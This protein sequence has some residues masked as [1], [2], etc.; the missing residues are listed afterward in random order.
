MN[1]LLRLSVV[2]LA[3]SLVFHQSI[4]A[5]AQSGQ[6]TGKVTDTQTGDLLPG[7]TVRVQGTSLGTATNVDGRYL[8]PKTPIGELTL[9]ISSVG[10]QGMETTVNVAPG[11]KIT[12]DVTLQVSSTQLD[13]IVITGLRKSQIDAINRKKQALN[14]K[15]VLTTNDIGRLPDINVAEAAQRVS[16]VSIETDNG[17]GRF[18]SIRG[19]QP[20]LN[21]VT[22][23]NTNIGST[24]GGRE[25][26]LDLMPVEMISS[27]EVTKAVTPDME[28]SAVGGAININTI[29]AFDK[30]ESQFLIASVDGLIQEQQADYGDDKFPFRAA[31][32]AGKRFGENEKFGAVVS[33]NFFR[34]DFTVSV[35]DPDRWQLLQGTDPNGNPSP[36]YLGPNEIEIQMEDNERD[37]YGVTADLEYQFT[38]N[39]SVYFRSLYT[40][41][42]ERRLNS[43]FELTVAG[44]G[45][46][47]NQT[48]TSGQFTA[49]SGELDLSSS[50]ENEDLYSFTLGT[51]HRLGAF[52]FDVY[53]T[54]S[55]A[56]QNRFNI[57]GTYENPPETEPLLAATYNV[58]PFF[59]D[60][61]AI[62]QEEARDP[63]LY[64]LRSLNFNRN[65]TVQENMYEA[66]IDLR[67]DFTLGTSIPAYI[68]IGGRYRSREKTVDNA[69]EEYND[70]REN[71]LTGD[72]LDK[73]S[74]P[75][76]LDQFNIEPQGPEQGGAQPNVHGDAEAFREFFA[77]P[78]TL[79]DTTRI[80]FRPYDTAEEIYDEDISYSEDV[81][82]GYIMG[83]VD[84][85][86][87]TL[88]AGVRVEHTATSSA[89]FTLLSNDETIPLQDRFEQLF[90]EN[91]Y[92]NIMPSVHLKANPF[93]NFIARLSWT[94]TLA[95]PD[96]D[97]LA[98]TSELEINETAT[99]GLFDGTFQGANAGLQPYEAM[100]LDLSLEYYFPS[101]GILSSG[102][103]YKDIDSY[104]FDSE[105]TQN[106]IEFQGIQFESLGLAR[107]LNLDNA[108]VR[109]VEATYDQAFTFLPGFWN[110]FGITA[111]VAL[112]DS[113]AEYPNR[114]DDD[115]P[116]IRQP[117]SVFNI[118]PYY[119]KYGFELRAAITYRSE[120][121]D[122]IESLSSGWVGD[123]VEAGFAV[124]DFDVYE[125]SRTAVD[126]TAA[127]TFPS[128]KFKILAQ[129][130]NLTNAP[131]QEY[132]GV[133][134]RYDRHQLF[135]ASYF[136]GFT[137][138]L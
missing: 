6:I 54:Y 65:N 27:I 53:G 8:I 34:R 46:V 64:V 128:Q 125:A 55:R 88:T 130:R 24:S 104:I 126:L 116:L 99:E 133:P 132:R 81:T 113:E 43:E 74:N 83:V 111:N 13:D 2:A 75:Y 123:A 84:F 67:Y 92:T 66:S 127:Y 97:Q 71:P 138:N 29:S 80:A 40:H 18:I 1:V 73:V 70:D 91:S 9:V 109:G 137:V 103:F 35:L 36:G 79:T 72:N 30:A 131:E 20:A 52:S 86:F 95:R 117:N 134:E 120:F 112:I 110:G 94:N 51:E 77:N 105:I 121:L 102:F 37:R 19:I 57:D 106:N 115:L 119:Q 68:K 12:A 118:I 124:S 31:V 14:T 38:P 15:E 59:F 45:E 78:E 93:D 89:P 48:P 129:A 58:S 22:L 21:N 136:L 33:A 76:R 41:N 85:D 61:T 63:S 60:I 26:P 28:G 25:T 82:A 4:L 87:M 44:V 107:S 122:E 3:T 39:N 135:G 10:Y 17:E 49:G 56:D 50:D 42:N 96:Y 90:F 114:E 62:N 11:E 100:N 47:I 16:G 98:G 101:G 108:I 32:T 23:N 69:Q 5:Q 7:A